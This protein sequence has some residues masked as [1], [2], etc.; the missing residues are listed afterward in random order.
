MSEFASIPMQFVGPI[1]LGGHLISGEYV[2]FDVEKMANNDHE[3]QAT[4]ITGILNGELMCETRFNNKETFKTK[5]T[6]K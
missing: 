6:D 5:K 1:R 2:E 3:N 4:N